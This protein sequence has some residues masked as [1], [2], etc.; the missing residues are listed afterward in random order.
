MAAVHN[1]NTAALMNNNVDFTL[2]KLEVPAE[3]MGLG[4][5]ISQ[6]RKEEAEDGRLHKTARRLGVLFEG[7]LPRTDELSRAYGTR[8]SEISSMPAINPR[9]GSNLAGI[10]ANHV[11]ADAASIWA[12]ATSGKVAIAVHLLA[13]MLARIFPPPEAISVWVELVQKQKE[14]ILNRHENVLYSEDRYSANLASKQEISRTDLACWDASARAWLQSA[15]QAKQY[16]HKQTMLILNNANVPV[17]DEGKTYASVMKAWTAALSAVNSLL[18]GVPQV[19]QDGAALLAISSW[20]LYPDMAVFGTC[21]VTINQKDPLFDSA[22]LLTLGL[23]RVREDTSSVYWSLPLACLQYY[24]RPVRTSRTLGSENSRVSCQEFAYIILGCLFDGWKSFAAT[25]EQGFK[26]IHQVARILVQSVKPAANP[27]ENLSWLDYLVVAAREVSQCNEPEKKVARLLLNLGRRRS[28]FLHPPEKT[29]QPLFGLSQID[30]LL[31]VL[32][33]DHERLELLREL[34]NFL[35][36][37][38]QNCLIRYQSTTETQHIEYASLLPV[39]K[40][41]SKR[42]NDG[43]FKDVFVS[44]TKQTRWIPL[45]SAQL[46]VCIRRSKEMCDHGQ[47]LRKLEELQRIEENETRDDRKQQFEGSHASTTYAKGLER[48]ARMKEIHDLELVLFIC[49][50]R[51]VIEKEGELCLPAAKYVRDPD[52]RYF[53]TGLILSHETNFQSAAVDLL[54]KLAVDDGINFAVST[55]FFVGDADLAAICSVTQTR[56]LGSVARPTPM[57]GFILSSEFL[58]DALPKRQFDEKKLASH[59]S[60]SCHQSIEAEIAS[61]RACAMM[62]QVYKSLPGASISAMVVEQCLSTAKWIPKYDTNFSCIMPPTLTLAQAFACIAMFESGTCDLD[63][64]ALTEVFAMSSGNSL[65]IAGALLCDPYE[66]LSSSEIR[67]V[68]GNVGRTGITFLISPAEVNVRE[69]DPQKWMAINHEPFDGKM[70]NHFE[71]TSIHLSSFTE[72]KISLVTENTAHHM[73]DS[74]AVLLETLVSVYDKGTWVAEVDIL[75]AF[76][77]PIR[78]VSCRHT[79]AD[80]RHSVILARQPC[81]THNS[82]KNSYEDIQ[83]EES[84]L[85][86]TSVESWDELIEAPHTGSIAIRAH[87]NWLARLAT[88]AL[89]TRNKFIPIILPETPCWECCAEVIPKSSSDRY[90]LI[91]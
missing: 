27:L 58:E 69:A 53:D 85:A 84:Q 46:R 74:A 13:C 4:A 56:T 10:F 16:Q 62:A 36:F 63:P 80:A 89:C 24:G 30:M 33:K 11:G 39:R 21:S 61:L 66:Q 3:Y 29:P 72:Y 81:A 22:A 23:Q 76:R 86:A 64:R 44:A 60:S 19:V 35:G 41:A 42:L 8:V 37:D 6:R 5:T 50:R 70:E 59:F 20:H 57:P 28:T 71:H 45:D 47:T 2:V 7:M 88:T 67:R 90:A 15:D 82:S 25:D 40:T 38:M 54:Q 32:K 48:S 52:Y 91:C 34:A 77:S 68:V 75:K 79:E 87:K 51:L 18:N 83:K 55:T 65:Y 12:A 26:W 73:I 14:W 9:E 43:N 78:R 31:P 49:Q 1:E 17:N